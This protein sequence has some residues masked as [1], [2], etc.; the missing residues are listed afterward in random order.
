MF[1]ATDL[2]LRQK[3]IEWLIK[4][5]LSLVTLFLIVP[6]LAIL[7]VLIHRGSPMISVEFLFGDPTNG[8]TAGGIFP[9]LVGTIWLVAVSLLVAIP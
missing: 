5:L 3:K 9:A 2:N 8:M 6:A 4:A 7:A 1:E